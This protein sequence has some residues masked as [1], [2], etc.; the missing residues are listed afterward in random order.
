[1]SDLSQPEK[2]EVFRKTCERLRGAEQLA[3]GVLL[4]ATEVAVL[5]EAIRE[6]STG[7]LGQ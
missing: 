2:Y 6:M 7:I 1:M 3:E 5:A 4:D